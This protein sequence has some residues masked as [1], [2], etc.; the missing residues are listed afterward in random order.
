[1]NQTV[2]DFD[3]ATFDQSRDGPRLNRQAQ[4]V[5]NVVRDG[6]WRTLHAIAEQTG[7]PEASVSAR[8]RD[9]RKPRFGSHSVDRRY[10]AQGV[11]EY[12]LE[13]AV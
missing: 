10:I 11:W 5:F 6:R 9:L 8:L 4:L 12:R 3:G 1:M 7:Q 2:M 13:V